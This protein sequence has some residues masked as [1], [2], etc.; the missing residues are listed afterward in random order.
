MSF[1][2]FHLT[3][4]VW[5]PQNWGFWKGPAVKKPGSGVLK[6]LQSAYVSIQPPGHLQTTRTNHPISIITAFFLGATWERAADYMDFSG[7]GKRL[8]C[9]TGSLSG[10]T[11]WQMLVWKW[12]RGSHYRL[13]SG[14]WK[15]WY[16]GAAPDLLQA[17]TQFEPGAEGCAL[18]RGVQRAAW[19]ISHWQKSAAGWHLPRLSSDPKR[20]VNTGFNQL[21]WIC[22]IDFGG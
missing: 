4:E 21:Y 1:R 17:A 22:A 13:P 8:F 20:P 10:S 2:V 18:D 19:K 16:P 5:K 11:R 6:V 15:W 14:P 7:S 3:R 9:A 12:P